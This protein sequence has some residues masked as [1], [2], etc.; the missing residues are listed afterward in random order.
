MASTVYIFGQMAVKSY[1]DYFTQYGSPFLP[2]LEKFQ[3]TLLAA[4][5]NGRTLEGEPFGNWTV[6]MQFPSKEMAYGFVTS[7]EYAPLMELRVNQL[8]DGAHAVLI[9]GELA[10]ME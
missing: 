2:I 8:T 1:E 10:A 7:E 3:G 4:T 6:L 9:P 5:I